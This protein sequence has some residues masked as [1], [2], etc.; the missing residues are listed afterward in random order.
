MT[1]SR[2]VLISDI[3]YLVIKGNKKVAIIWCAFCL[4]LD[5]TLLGEQLHLLTIK[6]ETDY[7]M[8]RQCSR[9]L[10]KTPCQ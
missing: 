5:Y 2:L 8:T 10:L 7:Y 9:Q 6:T 1:Y 4:G 3:T